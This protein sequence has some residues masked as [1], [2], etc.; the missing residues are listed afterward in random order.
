MPNRI[1]VLSWNVQGE[2]GISDERMSRQRDFL[3]THAE[4]VDI[5]LFQAVNYEKGPGEGWYGQLGEL[6]DY[7]GDTAFR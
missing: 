3:E 7:F 5:F 2:I 1:T 4:D 6:I